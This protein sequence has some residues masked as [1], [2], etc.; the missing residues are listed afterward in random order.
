MTSWTTSSVG[1]IW[2]NEVFDDLAIRDNVVECQ[3]LA[4][5]SLRNRERYG[6]VIANHR[7]THVSDAGRYANA[8]DHKRVGLEEPLK[9]ECGIRG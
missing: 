9:F 5:P 3:A 6:A 1:V 8:P 7:L 2:F 4:R